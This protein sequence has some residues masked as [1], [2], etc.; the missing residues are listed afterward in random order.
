LRET[1]ETSE[2][3]VI[4]TSERKPTPVEKA[5]GPTKE[6]KTSAGKRIIVCKWSV[7]KLSRMSRT[8]ADLV[9]RGVTLISQ[10]K[11]VEGGDEGEVDIGFDE[12]IEAI[13]GLMT[14][15]IDEF[16]FVVAQSCL[17]GDTMQNLE[18][19]YVL[20]QF[21]AEDLLEAVNLIIEQN[22]TESL[23]KKATS[24]LSGA[25]FLKRK[26]KSPTRKPS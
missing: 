14:D 9:K 24:L 17:D 15:A 23:L 25:P 5:F 19:D 12:I 22:I 6:F 1:V 8:L 13:V 11:K 26:R 2:T 10:G 20:E 7:A 4:E 3:A 18:K 16:A 21:D